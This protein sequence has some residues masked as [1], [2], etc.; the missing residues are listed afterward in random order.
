VFRKQVA[1][2]VLASGK[3]Q[4]QLAEAADIPV[5]CLSRFIRG[6]CGMTLRNFERLCNELGLRL[7]EGEERDKP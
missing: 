5:G 4:T 3:N 7:T 1:M 6:R 2:A